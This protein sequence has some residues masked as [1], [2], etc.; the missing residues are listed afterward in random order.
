L[1]ILKEKGFKDIEVV[2]VVVSRLKKSDNTMMFGKNAICI[3]DLLDSLSF[4][5]SQGV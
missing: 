2:V 4:L 1:I 3:I 5:F